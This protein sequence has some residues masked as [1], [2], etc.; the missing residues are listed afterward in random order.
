MG[1]AE[2]VATVERPGQC[3]VPL[4]LERLLEGFNNSAVDKCVFRLRPRSRGGAGSRA[5]QARA[6]DGRLAQIIEGVRERG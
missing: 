5:P 6:D 4:G 3:S 1:W 2:A